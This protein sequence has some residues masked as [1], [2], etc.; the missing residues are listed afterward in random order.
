MGKSLHMLVF[1]SSYEHHHFG[2]LTPRSYAADSLM[3]FNKYAYAK[4]YLI[5]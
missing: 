5:H 1:P 2:M 3:K 4:N